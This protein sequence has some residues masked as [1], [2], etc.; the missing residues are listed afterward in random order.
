MFFL[1]EGSTEILVFGFSFSWKIIQVQSSS[2]IFTYKFF[3][4][5]RLQVRVLFIPK[6]RH[7]R[8]TRLFI[9]HNKNKQVITKL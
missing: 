2:G 3:Y 6:Y 1:I 4:L 9:I 7:Q 5:P 8:H